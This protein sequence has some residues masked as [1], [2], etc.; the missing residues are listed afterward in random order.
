MTKPREGFLGSITILDKDGY[1]TITASGSRII[2][3]LDPVDSQDVATKAYADSHGGGGAGTWAQALAGG[4]TSDGYSPEISA[5]DQL[6]G[7]DGYDLTLAT[8]SGGDTVI[9]S[10]GYE[11]VRFGIGSLFM[12]PGDS[13]D[14]VIG[15]RVAAVDHE[16]RSISILAQPVDELAG[17][18]DGGD[19]SIEAGK[20]IYGVGGS[21]NIEAGQ[22]QANTIGGNVTISAGLGSTTTYGASVSLDGGDYNNGGGAAE[23]LGGDSPGPDPGGEVLIRAGAGQVTPSPTIT[24]AYISL[25]GGA[26]SAGLHRPDGYLVAGTMASGHD[27]GY[28]VI[29][30]GNHPGG[31]NAGS[32]LINAGDQETG[33]GVGGSV[34]IASGSCLGSGS[35]AG[36]V[37]ITAGNNFGGADGGS[38]TMTAGSLTTTGGGDGG[39]ITITAGTSNLGGGDGGDIL[40]E[41]GDSSANRDGGDV[42]LDAGA[43]GGGTGK[44]GYIILKSDGTEIVRF[45]IGSLLMQFAGSDDAV[46]GMPFAEEG[47]VDLHIRGQSCSS[48]SNAGSVKI[49]GG[50]NSYE[51]SSGGEVTITGGTATAGPGYGGG[52]SMSG[53]DGGIDGGSVSIFGGEGISSDGGAV[54]LTGGDGFSGG[55]VSIIAGAGV[56]SGGS[57][58]IIAGEGGSIGGGDVSIIAGAGGPSGGS[59]DII[60]GEGSS[61]GGDVTISAGQ[62][63]ASTDG[64]VIFKTTL[65]SGVPVEIARFDGLYAF[66]RRLRFDNG[67]MVHGDTLSLVTDEGNLSLLSATDYDLVATASGSGNFDVDTN[68]GDITLN[69]AAGGITLGVASGTDPINIDH[70]GDGNIYFTTE[71]SGDIYIEAEGGI[72]RLQG[73]DAQMYAG[74]TGQAIVSGGGSGGTVIKSDNGS[75]LNM[76]AN[77]GGSASLYTTEGGTLEVYS[78]GTARFASQAGTLDLT[79]EGGTGALT[80]ENQGSGDIVIDANTG[81]TFIK[82]NDV[83]IAEF[84]DGY[85]AIFG[86]SPTPLLRFGPDTNLPEDGYILKWDAIVTQATWVPGSV[87]DGY[88]VDLPEIA[89]HSVQTVDVTVTGAL[90]GDHVNITTPDLEDGL[91]ATGH[92]E[93][94][95]TVR[96]KVTN[97]TAGAVNPASQEF[98]ILV[99]HFVS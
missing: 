8:T 35:N 2:N 65:T 21:I 90:V 33:G 27:S 92:V 83:T 73:V 44:D 75:A 66:G 87:H 37:D 64:A 78:S 18:V 32:V 70:A 41:A 95:N 71:G 23:I 99:T 62:G 96:I 60:A 34:S 6:Q 14:F 86:V 28:V 39:N 57:I 22:G 72:A 45:G 61:T 5:G 82:Q 7:E 54:S 1:G 98:L 47:G 88:I 15:G 77:G 93:S 20:S 55:E 63:V 91:I 42:I 3:A 36:D 40:L 81:S 11:V 59:I 29:S 85:A 76:Y 43:T 89:A 69:S 30:A 38:I 4:N 50:T 74:G 52:L 94:D 84:Y 24:G 51:G 49:Q 12:R 80:I 97:V 53:G 79:I 58:D 10:D 25:L 26:A 67:G 31:A 19:V 46:I 68:A 17:A 9:T 16:G 48:A 13:D 56:Q